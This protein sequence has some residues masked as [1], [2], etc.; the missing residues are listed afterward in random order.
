MLDLRKAVSKMNEAARRVVF[1]FEAAG[2]KYWQYQ[3]L[4]PKL[5]SEEFVPSP[6]Y[7]YIVNVLYQMGIYANV[8]TSEYEFRQ[9]FPTLDEAVRAWQEN[10][11]VTTPRATE[12]IKGYLSKTL[13]KEEDGLG[14]KG[15][16]K[17][18]A[19]WWT[20]E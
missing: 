16:Q 13:E 6:D 3:E 1:I 7:I 15:T 2:Q 8:E 11:N 17:M 12:I 19:I 5:Y 20:K 18:V 10:L 9:Q 14:L 4:W